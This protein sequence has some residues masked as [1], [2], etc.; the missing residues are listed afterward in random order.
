MATL[1]T[2]PVTAVMKCGADAQSSASS[3]THIFLKLR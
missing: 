3:G 2:G 1:F